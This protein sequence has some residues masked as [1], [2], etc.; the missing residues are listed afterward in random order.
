[1]ELDYLDD[2]WITQFNNED[3]LYQEFY[4]DDIYFINLKIIYI[5]HCNEIE[6][7][8]SNSLLLKDKNK[9]TQEDLLQI[10]KQH[11]IDHQKR[12][13]LLSILKYNILL[14]PE[15][16]LKHNY[17]ENY[18]QVIKQINDIPFHKTISMFQDLNELIILF[19]D[20]QINNNH[21]N[22]KK[23]YIKNKHMKTKKNTL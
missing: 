10:L 18:L 12:Y 11:S 17:G 2:S 1:M 13:S 9:L 23:V 16:V 6:K 8:K 15:E 20:K 3:K 22:T 19:Y 7:I 5:N 14:N 4:K 21:V